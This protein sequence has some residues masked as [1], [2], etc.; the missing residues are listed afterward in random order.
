MFRIIPPL[1]I[2]AFVLHAQALEVIKCNSRDG[3]TLWAS[4]GKRTSSSEI[5]YFP[6]EFTLFRSATELQE[7]LIFWRTKDA[8]KIPVKVTAW[9]ISFDIPSETSDGGPSIERFYLR[10]YSPKSKTAYSGSW[11][12]QTSKGEQVTSVACSVY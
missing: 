11:V 8:L 5:T 12:T 1:L 3:K 6:T 9:T 4:F 2:S 7:R 10:R